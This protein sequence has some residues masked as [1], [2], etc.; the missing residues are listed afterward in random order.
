MKH[1]HAIL[2]KAKRKNLEHETSF[3]TW[4]KTAMGVESLPPPGVEKK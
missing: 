4:Q 3:T 2:R 1:E